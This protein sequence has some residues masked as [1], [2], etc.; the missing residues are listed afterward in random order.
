VNSEK[1]EEY[2]SYDRPGNTIES[3]G[4]A[5]H[6]SLLTI[7]RFGSAERKVLA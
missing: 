1:N 3:D 6:D 5:I 4:D 7:H 2:E